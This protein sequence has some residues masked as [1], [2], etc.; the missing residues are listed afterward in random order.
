VAQT[1]GLVI[2]H[3]ACNDTFVNVWNFNVIIDLTSSSLL[4]PKRPHRVFDPGSERRDIR[5]VSP[6]QSLL[7]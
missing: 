2:P 3:A 7:N 4:V 5:A 1:G 6:V